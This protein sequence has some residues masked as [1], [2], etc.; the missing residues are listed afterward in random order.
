MKVT[1][2]HTDAIEM[3]CL[4][5]RERVIRFR[6]VEKIRTEANEKMPIEKSASRR[7]NSIMRSFF[8]RSKLAAIMDIFFPLILFDLIK[9]E[10]IL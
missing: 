6:N 4:A 8:A 3:V 1:I 7:L 9:K 5:S 10:V 2:I